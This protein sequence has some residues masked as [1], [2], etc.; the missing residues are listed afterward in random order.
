MP[1][2]SIRPAQFLPFDS[3]RS[4]GSQFHN[5]FSCSCSSYINAKYSRQEL[6]MRQQNVN[7]TAV[8]KQALTDGI[9]LQEK[10]FRVAVQGHKV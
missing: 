3:D 7:V 5:G 8:R 6:S 9:S 4:P 2:G 1:P 10:V